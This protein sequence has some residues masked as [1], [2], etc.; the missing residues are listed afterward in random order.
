MWFEVHFDS[1]ALFLFYICMQKRAIE[2]EH[3]TQEVYKQI[4]QLK[5]KHEEEISTFNQLL[6]DSH[7]HKSVNH[8]VY[9]DEPE[10]HTGGD[11]GE[12]EQSACDQKWREEFESYYNTE[13]ELS[14]FGETPSSWFS[15]YDRC[16]I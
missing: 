4:D 10:T 7:L 6:A 15:G 3:E 12:T 2:A 13:E 9:D 14:K 5:R 1:N 11:V 8:P 16:N